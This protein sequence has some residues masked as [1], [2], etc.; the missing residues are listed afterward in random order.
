[1]TT[2]ETSPEE[3][4]LVTRFCR[5]GMTSSYDNNFKWPT[6]GPVSCDD[7]SPTP[8]CGHGLHGWLWGKGEPGAWNYY[9]TDVMLV[10]EVLKS[11]IVNLEGK[12][13]FPRGNVVYCG[14]RQ[15][16]TTFME[17]RGHT[18][19]MYGYRAVG[20]SE[21]AE[22]EGA[23]SV[24]RAGAY[25][26]AKAGFRGRATVGPD[27]LAIAGDGGKAV[28]GDR[29]TA[30][31]GA[32]GEATVAC[33]GRAIVGEKGTATVGVGGHAMCTGRHGRLCVERDNDTIAT[34]DDPKPGVF[35]HIGEKGN[36]VQYRGSD[37]PHMGVPWD[38]VVS[39][40]GVKL[41]S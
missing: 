27:G 37:P 2:Q 16:V 22:S 15:S 33:G 32:Y 36:I 13:K 6:E 7:W 31:T 1:M 21:T 41:H 9:T 24:V 5:E 25:G 12:V 19:I 23:R 34:K 28:A 10:V 17:E 35:Y 38:T 18:E 26:I 3:T 8:Q 11:D 30:V 40:M 29:G 4:V 39:H 14:D 20:D